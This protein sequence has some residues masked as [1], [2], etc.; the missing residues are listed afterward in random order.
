[1][2]TIPDTSVKLEIPP[3]ALEEETLIRMRIIPHHY[4]DETTLS[5]GSN[6]SVVVE[7]LP[8]RLKLLKAAKLTLPHCLVLKKGRRWTA[9]VYSSHHEEGKNIACPRIL[10]SCNINP[11]LLPGIVVY[12][13]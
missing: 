13:P 1:M 5:F 11:L 3:G 7:L 12:F 10:D 4:Q 6:S 2:L 9:R 8:S